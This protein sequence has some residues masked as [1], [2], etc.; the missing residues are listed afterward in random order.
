M[1]ASS[2]GSTGPKSINPKTGKPYG[3][4]FPQITIND[5][6][7]T[8]ALLLKKLGIKKLHAVIGS[9]MGGMQ[10]LQWGAE[11]SDLV[12]RIIC[13]S[14]P[15][16]AYP[17]SIAYRYVGRLAILNDPNWNNGYYYNDKPPL[18]G[19]SHARQIGMISYRSRTEW[20]IRFKRK[21]NVDGCIFS[22]SFEIE[23]FLKHVGDKFA[24]QFDANSFY[25]SN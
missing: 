23:N 5:I 19:L 10:A 9:S 21:T 18:K 25:E 2:Y 6:V 22:E 16:R 14:A 1:I 17:Q 11:H 4:K 8:Q 13:I 7:N 3:P 24:D 15:G 20:N 12:D